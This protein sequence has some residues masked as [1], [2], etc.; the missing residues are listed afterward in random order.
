MLNEELS[1]HSMLATMDF[2]P[3][4]KPVNKVYNYC[5]VY[6]WKTISTQSDTAKTSIVH[7]YNCFGKVEQVTVH[8]GEQ[9]GGAEQLNQG[10]CSVTFS[11]SHHLRSQ[12][13]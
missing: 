10:G 11:Y 9:R 12:P 8:C 7:P 1:V 3:P 13:S 2:S 5:K 6:N 4:R